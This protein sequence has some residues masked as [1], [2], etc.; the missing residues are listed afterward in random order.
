M[1][2][3]GWNFHGPRRRG[4]RSSTSQWSSRGRLRFGFFFICFWTNTTTRRHDLFHPFQDIFIYL[5]TAQPRD[6]QFVHFNGGWLGVWGNDCRRACGGGA[7]CRS[8]RSSSSS[9][10]SGCHDD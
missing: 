2:I 3:K 1:A 6:E 9:S 10:G 8:C 7:V 4:G 5:I